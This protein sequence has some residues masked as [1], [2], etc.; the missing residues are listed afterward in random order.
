MPY[1]F[2][3]FMVL[4]NCTQIF[5]LGPQGTFSDVAARK[6][7]KSGI[8]IS[9]T[10]TFHETLFKVSKDSDSVAVVPVENSVAGTVAQVQDSLVTTHHVFLCTNKPIRVLFVALEGWLVGWLEGY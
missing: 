2:I 10:K 1:H 5:T 3:G 6:I 9:Y 7:V 4:N 8:S